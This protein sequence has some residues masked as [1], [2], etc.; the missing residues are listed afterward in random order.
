MPT[1]RF[2]KL[3]PALL[4]SE[5]EIV[6]AWLPGERVIASIVCTTY[7]H[8]V[9]IEQAIVGFLS[10]HTNFPFEIIIHD[11]ASSD[12]TPAIIRA[13]QTRYPRIIKPVLQELNQFSKGNFKPLV[14]AAGYASGDFLAVCEGDDYWVCPDKLQRQVDYHREHEEVLLSVHR[15]HI[16]YLGEQSGQREIGD[17]GRSERL[18]PYKQVFSTYGQFAPTA[19]MVFPR[20]LIEGLPEFFYRTPIGDFFLEAMAGINGIYYFPQAMSIYRFGAE[21]SWSR[22]TLARADSYRNYCRRMLASLDDLQNWL[23]RSEAALVDKKRAFVFLDMAFFELGLGARRESLKFWSKSY[24]RP[25]LPG[26]ADVR[27]L[28]RMLG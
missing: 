6:S 12:E 4:R 20:R 8:E 17:Y 19:S 23:P 26:R 5:G 21:Q 27:L 3:D 9:F 1:D 11:D 25:R 18:L 2:A 14:Y 13:W 10:Q 24:R 7:N 16:C 28:L 22:Q 15:A